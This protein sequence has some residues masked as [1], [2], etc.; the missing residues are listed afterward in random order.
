MS[1]TKKAAKNVAFAMGSKLLTLLVNFISRT[2][3]IY[4]L[5]NTCLGIN[6]LF[7]EVL[8]VLSFAELGFGTAL[9]FSMYKPVAEKD[10][11]KIVKLLHYY[12]QVYRV[13]ALIISVVGIALIPFLQYLVKSAE[14]VS[15]SEI[16]LYYVF[17]LLNTVVG[18]FVSYKFSLVNAEQKN[19]I[20]TNF[21]FVCNLVTITA[22]IVIVICF[23]NY[24]LY[25]ITHTA[26]L[27]VSRFVLSIYLNKKFPLLKEKCIEQLSKEEKKPIHTEVKGL[28][29]HQFSSVAIH[30][31]DNII[32]SSLTDMGVVAVGFI[33][34]YNM[35]I[36]AVTGM[37]SVVFNAIVSGFGNLIATASSK[38]VKK[39]FDEAN[40]VNFWL[41]G[42][43][44]IAFYILIP[45]FITLWIGEEYLI[46]QWSFLLIVL[47]CYLMGQSVVYNN[48][49]VAYGNFN[50]DKW[51]SMVQAL[52]NLV[53]SIVGAK[54][55]GLM[56]VYIGT[57]VSRAFF[58]LFRPFKTYKMMFDKSVISYYK[59]LFGYGGIVIVAGLLTK[60]ACNFCVVNGRIGQFIISMLWVCIIPNMVFLVAFGRTKVFNNVW[61]RFKGV[62]V[63]RKA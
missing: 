32:I 58:V 53:V 17:F 37:L 59:Q 61:A 38:E 27:V 35:I 39:V 9:N 52:I 12:K 41:Y 16:R 60:I 24:L 14:G 46:D 4:Y 40:F 55:W 15:I 20:T 25:L 23:R 18:Y 21:E 28:I 51:I 34:N 49:R 36:N 45:P 48:V 63:K 2:I 50:S 1:R 13:V 26:C 57:I 56:G 19:Y 43:V 30:Q 29:F 8:Q 3:F 6:G 5:G 7:T 33:S 11:Q 62:I 22:Q 42:F 47:N 44:C 54:L 31:T 10:E